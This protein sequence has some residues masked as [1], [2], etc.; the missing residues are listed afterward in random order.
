MYNLR[1]GDDHMIFSDC[2]RIL[3]Q[4]QFLSQ[5]AIAKELQVTLS[6]VSRWETG[7]SIPNLSTMKKIK[8]FC[9]K[10]KI[11]YDIVEQ[12]WLKALADN[13]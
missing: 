1:T 7:K 8:A 9:E 6:T 12:S 3:R 5:E 13:K 4:K 2:I 10:E 11:E